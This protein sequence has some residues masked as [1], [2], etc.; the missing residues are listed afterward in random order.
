MIKAS[1]NPK[2][3][4]RGSIGLP[5]TVQAWGD[6]CGVYGER[7]SDGYVHG[8]VYTPNRMGAL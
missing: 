5:F 3:A 6:A 1:T 4:F 8:S 7:Y 2:G